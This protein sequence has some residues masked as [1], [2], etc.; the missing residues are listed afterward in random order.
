MALNVETGSGL[1]NANALIS[2]AKCKEYWS[3]RGRPLDSYSDEDVEGAI[4]RATDYVSNRFAYKGYRTRRRNYA[5]PSATQSLEWPREGVTDLRD[6]DIEDSFY[7]SY[8]GYL[9][10]LV[11]SDVIPVEVT[12][13]VAEVARAEL[14]EPGIFSPMFEGSKVIASESVGPMSVSYDSARNSTLTATPVIPAV[15]DYLAPFLKTSTTSL[16]GAAHR[17]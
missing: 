17:A 7:L 9:G 4:V 3:R 10:N 2:L 6:F 16:S 11:P 15:N 14:E 5:N 13:A 8:S 12:Y 1:S